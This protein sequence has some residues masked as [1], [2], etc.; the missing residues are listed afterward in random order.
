TDFRD[1]FIRAEVVSTADL[2][3]AGS[4]AAARE[5]GKLLAAGKDYVVRDGDVMV[6]LH[7]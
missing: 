5:S 7:G 1:K 3:A 6:F 2:L 4:W